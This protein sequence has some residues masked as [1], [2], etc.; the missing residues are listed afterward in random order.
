MKFSSNRFSSFREVVL[1]CGRA[2]G[3]TTEPAYT[4]NF[5]GAFGSGELKTH[6]TE[7]DV[8]PGDLN[9]STKRDT[10]QFKLI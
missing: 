5:P 6:E 9:R 7:S 3:R 10:G 8:L 4:I 2:D 1:N